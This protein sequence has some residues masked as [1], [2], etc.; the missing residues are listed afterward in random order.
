MY[1]RPP[2]T[3]PEKPGTAFANVASPYVQ[4]E[5]ESLVKTRPVWLMRLLVFGWSPCAC[6]D[7]DGQCH[8]PPHVDAPLAVAPNEK[9]TFDAIGIG[10]QI[11]VCSQD[12]VTSTIAWKFRAPEATL[13][14]EGNVVGTHYA[15]PTWQ[16]LSGGTVVGHVEASV[17][18]PDPTKAIPWLRLSAVS[19]TGGGPFAKVSSIQRLATVGGLIPTSGCDADHLGQEARIPYAAHYFFYRL[20]GDD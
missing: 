14:S 20:D 11:Y 15:G 12:P 16:S 9:L 18:A 17:P 2:P 13:Y 5:K 4:L 8:R 6:A 10:V 3:A 1:D 7:E 19:H